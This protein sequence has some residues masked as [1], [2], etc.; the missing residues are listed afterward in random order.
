MLFKATLS[1]LFL[2]QG[3]LVSAKHHPV[4]KLNDATFWEKTEGK[5]IFIKFFA[6]WCEH[7]QDL[8]PEFAKLAEEWEGHENGMIVEMDCEESDSLETCYHD[9]FNV[10]EYP[11]LWYGDP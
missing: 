6:P 2:L 8:A 9:P 11:T 3:A 1:I 7:C 10:E 5:A 4:L